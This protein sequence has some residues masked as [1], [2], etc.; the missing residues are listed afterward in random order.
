MKLW[1][2]L[3]WTFTFLVGIFAIFVELSHF[4]LLGGTTSILRTFLGGTSQKRHPVEM[5]FLHLRTRKAITKS[6][7]C[8]T[9]RTILVPS[10]L[11]CLEGLVD[12]WAEFFSPAGVS[13]ISNSGR[14]CMFSK[15]Q[16]LPG[17]CWTA[18]EDEIMSKKTTLQSIGKYTTPLQGG[19]LSIEQAII[20]RFPCCVFHSMLFWI[21]HE[22][23]IQNH[24]HKSHLSRAIN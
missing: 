7:R 4:S 24:E 21:C 18:F 12:N 1:Q 17:N 14:I 20:S 3:T 23:Q 15:Q 9:E 11:T 19:H 2:T 8:L 6:I 22:T 10:V 5:K 13:S 16:H